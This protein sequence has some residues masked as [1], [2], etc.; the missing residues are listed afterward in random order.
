M[1]KE[2]FERRKA[3]EYAY[4]FEGKKIEKQKDYTGE[5]TNCKS[6]Y[7]MWH[8]YD[9]RI[10]VEEEL[11]DDF[12]RWINELSG[13]KVWTCDIC[14]T[15]DI[16]ECINWDDHFYKT[17]KIIVNTKMLNEAMWKLNENDPWK[18]SMD[19]YSRYKVVWR[20]KEE[21]YKA[22]TTGEESLIKC[23]QY[24]FKNRNTK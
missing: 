9:F 21:Y 4:Y 2:E 13:N 1:T 12:K 23:L 8:K 24:I 16:D 7:F 3:V 18:I 11:S 20:G 15:D 17:D 19:D 5:W 22:C 10:K 14:E 6:P